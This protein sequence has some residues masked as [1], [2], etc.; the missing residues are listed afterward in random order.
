M[1]CAYNNTHTHSRSHTHSLTHTLTHSQVLEPIARVLF[2]D[3]QSGFDSYHGFSIHVGEGECEGVREG[4]WE[5]D[6]GER[7]SGCEGTLLWKNNG[8]VRV[9]VHAKRVSV[10]VERVRAKGW[11][12]SMSGWVFV[13]PISMALHHADDPSLNGTAPTTDRGDRLPHH[14]DICEVPPRTNIEPHP[15]IHCLRAGVDECLF[16]QRTLHRKR[17]A[18]WPNRRRQISRGGDAG[19]SGGGCV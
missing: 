18:L 6:G 19:A 10:S 7:Q 2:P 12:W 5:G 4:E 1:H 14:I 16:G 13:E 15:S 17:R 11:V 9:S 8:V 3:W